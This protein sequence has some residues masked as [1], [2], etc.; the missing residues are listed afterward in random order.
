MMFLLLNFVA[1]ESNT[2]HNPEAIE[3]KLVK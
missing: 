2:S 1:R 3:F